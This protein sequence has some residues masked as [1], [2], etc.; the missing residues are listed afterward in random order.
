MGNFMQIGYQKKGESA[1]CPGIK[2]SQAPS[3][4]GI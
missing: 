4:H 2:K 3:Y 1:I